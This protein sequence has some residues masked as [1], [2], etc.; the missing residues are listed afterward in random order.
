MKSVALVF[1]MF[2]LFFGLVANGLGLM[3]LVYVLK[4]GQNVASL[5]AATWTCELS[6][7]A[8]FIGSPF[9]LL[10]FACGFKRLGIATTVLCI[11]C[12]PLA[13]LTMRLV[14]NGH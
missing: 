12:Y 13:A 4:T 14:V 9:G 5:Y 7:A 1:G 11:L 6:V 2:S 3:S 10:A 8:V